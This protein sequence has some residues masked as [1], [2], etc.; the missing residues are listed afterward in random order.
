MV[1]VGEGC[2]MV[3]VFD[4]LPDLVILELAAVLLGDGTAK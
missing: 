3:T 4:E 1:P 2:A